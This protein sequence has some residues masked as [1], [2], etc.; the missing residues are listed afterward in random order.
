MNAGG[1]SIIANERSRL[2]LAA[3]GRQMWSVTLHKVVAFQS[4]PAGVSSLK[5][6]THGRRQGE[7]PNQSH[8]NKGRRSFIEHYRKWLG[9]SIG[10]G[11]ENCRARHFRSTLMQYRKLLLSAL[12]RLL[13]EAGHLRDG[14]R[15]LAA[16]IAVQNA[17]NVRPRGLLSQLACWQAKCFYLG[18]GFQYYI[19]SRSKKNERLL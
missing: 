14:K 5:F 16:L 17:Q 7:A 11:T 10:L 6:P 18:A 9:R 1:A 13:Q 19:P 4:N 8:N 2:G 3:F 12:I 15:T